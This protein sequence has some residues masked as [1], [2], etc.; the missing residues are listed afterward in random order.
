MLCNVADHVQ[1]FM[2]KAMPL[3]S[4]RLQFLFF[5][6]AHFKYLPN[7][8]HLCELNSSNSSRRARAYSLNS[9]G[10]STKCKQNEQKKITIEFLVIMIVQ[11]FPSRRRKLNMEFNR[12]EATQIFSFEN[13]PLFGFAVHTPL[14]VGL[15]SNQIETKWEKKNTK[16]FSFGLQIND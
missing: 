9:Y 7:Y 11:F 10:F 13:Y 6:I 2:K 5:S 8:T 1:K 12:Y 4:F 3:A 14:I 15:Q 16:L